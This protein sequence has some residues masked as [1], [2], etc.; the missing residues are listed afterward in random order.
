M[1]IFVCVYFLQLPVWVQVALHIYTRLQAGN[2]TQH[3][4]KRK[5]LLLLNCWKLKYV[6]VEKYM[7]HVKLCFTYNIYFLNSTY[8]IFNQFKSKTFPCFCCCWVYNMNTAVSVFLTIR[9]NS[10]KFADNMN[11]QTDSCIYAMANYGLN[12]K[13]MKLKFKIWSAKALTKELMQFH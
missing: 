12:K 3:L 1:V 7:L 13:M 11:S 10:D 8:F 6:E 4:K 9:V 5:N 2:Y